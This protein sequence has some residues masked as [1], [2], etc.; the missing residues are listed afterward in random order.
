M[1]IIFDY[2]AFWFGLLGIIIICT[3]V[4]CMIIIK[5]YD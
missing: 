1:D 3:F 5:Y 4:L 2:K